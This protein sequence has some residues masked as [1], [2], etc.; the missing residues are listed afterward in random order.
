MKAELQDPK[1]EY[2]MICAKICG[3]SHFNMKI[4]VVIESRAE[5]EK[6]LSS[7]TGYFEKKPEPDPAVVPD[8]GAPTLDPTKAPGDSMPPPTGDKELAKPAN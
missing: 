1:F 2:Y 8:S 6:W 5:Y 7:Q 4:K 3:A